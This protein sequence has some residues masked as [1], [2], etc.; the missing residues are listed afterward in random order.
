MKKKHFEKYLAKDYELTIV[1]S[2]GDEVITGNIVRK[3]D[4]SWVYPVVNGIPRFLKE[5]QNYASNF[6]IQW[7]RYRTTQL[8]SVA[9]LNI[10]NERFYKNTKWTPEELNGKVVLEAGSGA[11]RFTEILLKAGAQVV[12]FDYSLAV[13][14]NLANNGMKGDLFIFQ[15]DIYDIPFPDNYFDY[16]FCY[17]VIQ[18]TPDPD[19]TYQCLFSKVKPGG[20]ISIDSY[21][22]VQMPR[23][24][25]TIFTWRKITTRMDPQLLLKIVQFYVPLWFPVDTFL[26]KLPII[27]S[28][29][30]HRLNIPCSNYL[31]IF[32]QL[33]KKQL[34]EWAILDTYDAL[35]AKYDQPKTIEEVEYMVRSAGNEKQECF[36]GSNGIVANVTKKRVYDP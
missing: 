13:Q 31:E 29:I 28:Q 3:E 33:S 26:I 4:S 18:H 27:G 6:G 11:G 10:S 5:K 2:T 8:D 12:S 20:K 23:F 19:K 9:G 25:P 34:L 35:G 21:K 7:N 16:V 17:G 1:E 14:A 32:P 36:Y 24:W 22:K 30:R 15:G